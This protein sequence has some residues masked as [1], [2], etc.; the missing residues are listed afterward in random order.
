MNYMGPKLTYMG[1]K[2][3]YKELK[4][5]YIGPKL[6]YMGPKLTLEESILSTCV[7]KNSSKIGNLLARKWQLQT[8]LLEE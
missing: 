8:Q 7:S 2:L 3:T 5:T 4:V 6:T 1:L